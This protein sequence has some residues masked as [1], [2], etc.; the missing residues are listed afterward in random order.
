MP[1]TQRRLPKIDIKVELV[2]RLV[3]TQFPHWRDLPVQPVEV[4][5]W[6]NRTFRLGEA[7]SVRLPSAASYSEQVA[8]EQR[9]LPQL[10]PLLPLTIPTPLAMGIP[11][12]DYPWHWSIYRW[13]EGENA[14]LQRVDEPIQF[15][16]TLA[17]FLNAL[18]QIDTQ[19]GPVPGRH[20]FFRGDSLAIYDRETRVAVKNLG[21]RINSRVATEVWE[22][23]LE[24]NWHEQ[25]VWLHGDVSA[26]N[27]LV[28][29]GKLIAVIDFGC[30]AIGDPACDLA[31]TWT[32]FS[33]SNRE[34]FRNALP[35]DGGTWARG[36][37]WALWKALITL[38]DSINTNPLKARQAQQVID[39]VLTDHMQFR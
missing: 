35:A 27:L 20:N 16:T 7:M 12:S 39:E 30:C 9:W 8:K 33:G 14:V 24:A 31:I 5:G 21:D 37:G 2:K 17:Q 25:P 28:R 4:D 10:F 3:A 32:F 19:D 36:R 1:S 38:A 15:A 22:A 13:I 29:K 11:D 34:A 6:D 23:A 26:G 18:Q